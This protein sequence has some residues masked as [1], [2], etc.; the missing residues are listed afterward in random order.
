MLFKL[1]HGLVDIGNC[2]KLRPGDQ[3]TWSEG[4]TDSTSFQQPS[5]YTN[6]PSFPE[7]SMIGN[8][9]QQG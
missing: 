5:A 6:F 8:D 9:F 2:A 1:Q 3:R 4:H 7:L